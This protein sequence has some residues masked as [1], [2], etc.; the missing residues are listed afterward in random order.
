MGGEGAWCRHIIDHCLSGFSWLFNL[1]YS[2]FFVIIISMT[3]SGCNLLHKFHTL[4]ITL[5]LAVKTERLRT[6]T[7][8]KLNHLQDK[9]VNIRGGD[10]ILWILW[11]LKESFG[12]FTLV[13]MQCDVHNIQQS[14][15]S[16]FC[17]VN[18]FVCESQRTKNIPL[19]SC[20]HFF[21][22]HSL[23]SMCTVVCCGQRACSVKSWGRVLVPSSG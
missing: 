20:I 19:Y 23:F 2:L 14:S 11:R 4:T 16:N 15:I 18:I 6:A 9:I 13:K 21:L 5:T 8:Y 10:K 12:S 17:H 22:L 1:R 3:S 7:Y